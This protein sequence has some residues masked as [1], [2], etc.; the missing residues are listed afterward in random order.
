MGRIAESNPRYRTKDVIAKD[1]AFVLDSQLSYGTK[2]AVLS[3]VTW[4]WTEFDGKY[5]G[6]AYWSKK[7]VRQ[8]KRDPHSKLRHD[9]SVPKK[10][11]IEMLL[12]MPRPTPTKVR[13][14]L[15]KFLI[16]VVVTPDEHRL[17]HAGSDSTEPKKYLRDS[18]LRYK[19]C[20]VKVIPG[21]W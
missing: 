13:R 2:F 10:I 21:V 1:V 4:V 7:A 3:D 12:R 20:G 16:G 11:V 9:H 19:K 8:R 15:N 18:W 14:M 6:C 17:L 5:R